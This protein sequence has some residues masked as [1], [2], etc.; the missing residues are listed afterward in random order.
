MKSAN[1]MAPAGRRMATSL[2]QR[3]RRTAAPTFFDRIRRA[4][5][6]LLCPVDIETA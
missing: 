2:Q 4:G 6:T 5:L 1:R 3:G